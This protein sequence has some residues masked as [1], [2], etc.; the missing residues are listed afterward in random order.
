VHRARLTAQLLA[1][2]PARDPLAVAERLLAIQG[3]DPRGFR[4]AV[5]ARSEGLS[6]AHVDRALTEERSLLVTWLNRGTLHLVRS[7][8][9]ALLHA[10][11]TPPLRTGSER[12]LVQEGLPPA[13]AERGI[14][15]IERALVEEGPLSAHQ[16]RERVAAAS[17]RAQG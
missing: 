8:D 2:P 16:L 11:T 3:Q 12:R 9:Y 4:L 13:D 5:R 1:G 15:A 7:E 10:V 17:V 6:A 14:A